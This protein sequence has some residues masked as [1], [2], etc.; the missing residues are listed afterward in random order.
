MPLPLRAP[1]LIGSKIY[2]V[3]PGMDLSHQDLSHKNLANFDFTGVNLIGANF[4]KAILSYANF[5]RASLDAADFTDADLTN[6]R[7]NAASLNVAT[8]KGAN[9]TRA[10]WNPTH[11]I[12]PPAGWAVSSLTGKLR[13]S[14]DKVLSIAA[15]VNAEPELALS[16]YLAHEFISPEELKNLL[17][18]LSAAT[19]KAQ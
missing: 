12:Q 19:T 18:S 3:A 2:D 11:G 17:Y 9:L 5:N 14:D 10:T 4:F 13:L 8:F 7:F 15:S 16:I 1:I 6:A